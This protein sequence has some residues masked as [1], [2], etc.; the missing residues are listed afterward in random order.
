FMYNAICRVIDKE[1]LIMN[2]HPCWGNRWILQLL[3]YD[4]SLNLIWERSFFVPNRNYLPENLV[5]CSTGYLV[6]GS[7]TND[8]SHNKIDYTESIFIMKTDTSGTPV[9]QFTTPLD[10][11]YGG[12]QSMVETQDSGVVF[13]SSWK[14]VDLLA[15]ANPNN[16]AHWEG[17]V[18]VVK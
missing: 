7:L 9:W 1:L 12:T 17:K 3:K 15:P 11:V 2:L 14:A 13:V 10:S 18:S 16:F 8:D 6:S 4:S 5:R